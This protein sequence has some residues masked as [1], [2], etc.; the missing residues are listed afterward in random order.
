MNPT[1]AKY[2]ECGCH[3]IT[4]PDYNNCYKF[5]GLLIAVKSKIGRSG[6]RT[7]KYIL[8]SLDV[9]VVKKPFLNLVKRKLLSDRRG[10]ITKIQFI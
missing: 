10:L 7:C 6:E 9:R 8:K 5:S 4:K 1:A 3:A 2:L